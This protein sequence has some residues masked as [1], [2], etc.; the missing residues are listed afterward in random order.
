MAL[1]YKKI[2]SEFFGGGV[3]VPKKILSESKS[4]SR[5]FFSGVGVGIG[6]EKVESA[7]HYYGT[8]LLLLR[9]IQK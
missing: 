3:G 4:E 7:V 8:L 6:I 9:A 1:K 5:N 2:F